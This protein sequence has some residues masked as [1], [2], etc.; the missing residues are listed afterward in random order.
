MTISEGEK[1]LANWQTDDFWY[2]ALIQKIDLESILVIYDDSTQ[3]YLTLER[4]RPLRIYEGLEIEARWMGKE[5][6]Y[7]GKV[8]RVN[9]KL[10]RLDLQME[11]LSGYH[12]VC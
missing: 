5:T 4:I 8:M 12:L 1:V 9:G 6:Y 10:Q 3:E 11:K 7:Q 2:V